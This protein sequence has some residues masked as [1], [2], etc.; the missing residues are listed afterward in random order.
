VSLFNVLL[1]ID[2]DHPGDIGADDHHRLTTYVKKVLAV[3]T[4]VTCC[5]LAALSVFVYSRTRRREQVFM[6]MFR[7]IRNEAA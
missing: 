2:P 7:G 6:R 3:A 5:R 4:R 1:D